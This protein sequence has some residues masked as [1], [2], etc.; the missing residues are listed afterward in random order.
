MPCRCQGGCL[1]GSW[2]GCLL[3]VVG[4]FSWMG[5]VHRLSDCGHRIVIVMVL[6]E[7]KKRSHML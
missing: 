2:G 1:W 5:G 3:W 7:E 6:V 4:V